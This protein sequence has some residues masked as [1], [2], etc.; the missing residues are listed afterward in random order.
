MSEPVPRHNRFARL[1]R[2]RRVAIWLSAAVVAAVG[3]VVISTPSNAALRPG[4]AA[5]GKF[6]GF[7][8][9]FDLLCN[10][11]AA[12]TSGNSGKPMYRSIAGTEF[13]QVTP[14]NAMKWENTENTQNT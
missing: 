2:P 12:C 7:A 13:N 9:N 14:E 11:Q 8:G 5:H 6:I 10:S 3:V 4:A 1:R